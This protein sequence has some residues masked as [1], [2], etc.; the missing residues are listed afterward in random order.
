M[1]A[2]WFTN[3]GPAN[4]SASSKA[5]W[6][7]G[8]HD[9]QQQQTGSRF[10]SSFDDSQLMILIY[11]D[12]GISYAVMSYGHS[13]GFVHTDPFASDRPVF[14]LRY[15]EWCVNV[16]CLMNLVGRA[17]PRKEA[18]DLVPA[19]LNTIVYVVSS[20]VALVVVSEKWRLWLI[21]VSFADY[22]VASWNQL[23]DWNGPDE[24]MI[25]N[26]PHVRVTR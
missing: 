10:L 6:G 16:F 11:F 9:A 5:L 8:E 23:V 1:V 12:L 14:S 7:G 26:S 18:P 19:I 24:A 13:F 22:G 4:N 15:L 2:K 20:W 21:F 3:I 25:P 17:I